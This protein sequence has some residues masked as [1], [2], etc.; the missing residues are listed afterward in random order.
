MGWVYE[1]FVPGEV[2][3]LAGEGDTI[4]LFSQ[5]GAGKNAI[6]LDCSFEG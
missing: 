3:L 4:A 2:A 6:R 5:C 1:S